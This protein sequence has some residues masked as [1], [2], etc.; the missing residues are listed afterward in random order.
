MTNH[1]N[2]STTRPAIR[3]TNEAG[4]EFHNLTGVFGRVFPIA[5]G[6]VRQLG[7]IEHVTYCGQRYT[8]TR[9]AGINADTDRR[10]AYDGEGREVGS[11]TLNEA[12]ARY[13]SAQYE[14]D[15]DTITVDP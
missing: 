4:E 10:M 2:R 12:R 13:G 1:P 15:S 14:A 9:A 8:I 11:L 7:A 5:V 6:N 3:V